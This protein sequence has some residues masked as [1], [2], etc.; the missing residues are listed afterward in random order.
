M[1]T[2]IFGAFTK[3]RAPIQNKIDQVRTDGAY[4]R[5]YCYDAIDECDATAD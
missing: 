2:Y 3:Q 1:N 5:T 4:D